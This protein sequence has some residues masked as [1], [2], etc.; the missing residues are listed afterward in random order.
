MELFSLSMN[1]D[2]GEI[3]RIMNLQPEL[4]KYSRKK[5]VQNV[6]NVCKQLLMKND[7]SEES[8]R[9]LK[10]MVR[11]A[12]RKFVALY[13]RYRKELVQRRK[14]HNQ[15]QEIKGNIRVMCR[16]RPFLQHEISKTPLRHIKRPVITIGE[17]HLIEC[18]NET[19]NKIS[20]FE[21]DWAFRDKTTQEELYLEVSPLIIS[22]V[23]G[24]N[25][26]IMA[27]GQT[28]SGKTFTM[29]G[30]NTENK[31]GIMFRAMR[32]LFQVIQD[33]RDDGTYEYSVRLQDYL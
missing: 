26:C 4:K 27:Y 20:M 6:M 14:L 32:E 24:Y 10:E 12:N 5:N 1:T 2:V 3:G 7:N 23:D 8:V 15:L 25:V 22:C 28:G 19:T 31:E 13:E 29:E 17:D 18:I 33:R 11:E 16:L 21:F 30:E 9:G